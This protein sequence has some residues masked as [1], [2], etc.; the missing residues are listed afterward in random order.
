MEIYLDNNACTP[1]DPRVI[2]A[3]AAAA[4]QV[5]NPQSQV[6]AHGRAAADRITAGAQDVA[7]LVDCDPEEV[8]FVPGATVALQLALEAER[9]RHNAFRVLAGAA[10]HPAILEHL[11]RIGGLRQ[12][13]VSFVPVDS[14][15]RLQPE[16][17]ASTL[18][19]AR[20]HLVCL[21]AANNEVGT[22]ERLEKMTELAR[23][24]GA[25]VLIDGS[26]NVGKLPI[27]FSDLGCD[28]LVLSGAKLYGLPRTAAVI[29]QRAL[30]NAAKARFGSPDAPA[31][32]A[33][34]VA[35][36]LRSEEMAAD[37]AG[38]AVLR[39]RLQAELKMAF[40][41][42][43]I[44]G[45][46]NCRLAGTLSFAVPNCPNDAVLDRLYGRLSLS[47]GAACRSGAIAPSHVLVAMGVA[48]WVLDG[49]LRASV[50]KSN[51]LAEVDL[52]TELITD[53]ITA[54]RNAR[55]RRI[56]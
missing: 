3:Y 4:A 49:V 29:S 50:G 39:D 5:G 51:T 43:V 1:V 27:S 6:H 32:V 20:P 7:Q 21:T 30:H 23:T 35:C 11:G 45:D 16:I 40:P 26:Q 44:N 22:V 33:L 36:R 46:E 19:L 31:A 12:A 24:A 34:G 2:E 52:A 15:G 42:M 25:V 13:D 10:D 37:E 47:T 55:Q 18:Q 8:C 9:E 54:V 14:V 48:D 41:D 56:A 38:I 17:F 53:A 28:Q